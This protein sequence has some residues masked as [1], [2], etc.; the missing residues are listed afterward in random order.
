MRSDYQDERK[1]LPQ[2]F[3]KTEAIEEREPTALA[4]T[5]TYKHKRTVFSKLKSNILE[6]YISFTK[7]A[8]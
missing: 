2:H 1:I 5:Y 3:R 8:R 4:Q 6:W 7:G